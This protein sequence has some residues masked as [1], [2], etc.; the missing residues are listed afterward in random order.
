VI[1][2]KK[3]MKTFARWKLYWEFCLQNHH[4]FR[5]AITQRQTRATQGQRTQS[6]DRWH[7]SPPPTWI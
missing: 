7:T 3:I 4:D 1:S 2:L 5:V 6:S